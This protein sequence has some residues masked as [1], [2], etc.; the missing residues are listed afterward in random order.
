MKDITSWSEGTFNTL[1][2]FWATIA[3]FAPRI[4]GGLFLLLLGWVIAKFVS[5][6]V[7]KLFESNRMR[8]ITKSFDESDMVK[9]VDIDLSLAS[10]LSKFTYW[11]IMILFLVIVSDNMGWSVVSE[12]IGSLFRYLPKL[13]IATIIFI[14]GMYIAG[15]V[16]QLLK[17]SL[18]SMSFGGAPIVSTVV[19]YIIMVIISVT[20]LNQAG[21]ATDVISN[22]LSIIIGAVLLAFALGFGLASRDLI[23]KMLF[24]YYSHQSFEVGQRIKCK[25]IEGEIVTM[26]NMS[27]HVRT[28]QG[29]EILPM[30]ILMSTTTRVVQ[31]N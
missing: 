24:S 11:V 29:I 9:D 15:V 30:D 22:N 14:I 4:I 18:N 21:I 23:R 25:D 26:N 3:T 16:R 28:A 6:L 31:E 17:A 20:A 27:A 1:E 12:E 19:Y 10:I 5:K 2:H 8:K 13:L 7:K